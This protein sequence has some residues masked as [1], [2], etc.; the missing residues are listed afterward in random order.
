[1]S[2]NRLIANVAKK[3][4]LWFALSILLGLSG[5]IFNGIG[6]TLIIPLML[7][8]LG[9]DMLR[10]DDLPPLLS[11]L[12]S[13]FDRVP[14]DSKS[15]A[16]MALLLVALL[17]KN[18]ASYGSTAVSS[19]LSRNYVCSLRQDGL[20]LLLD[21]D[22]DYY[23]SVRLGDLMNYLNTEINRVATAVR[24]LARTTTLVITILV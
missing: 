2:A 18:L 13:V 24:T 20:R 6:I 11:S 17:L 19:L 7:D 16:L 22:L 4:P 12:F 9:Q 14:D 21:V 1:M 5:A 15:L 3:S 23:A 10:A 8:L